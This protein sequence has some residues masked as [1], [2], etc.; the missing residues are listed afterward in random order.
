MLV[1]NLCLLAMGLSTA[2]GATIPASPAAT[3]KTS[4][5]EATEAPLETETPTTQVAAPVPKDT[6]SASVCSQKQL[7]VTSQSNLDSIASCKT[8]KGDIVFSHSLESA[9]LEGVEVIEGSLKAFNLTNLNWVAAPE[10]KEITGTLQLT[11]LERLYRASFPKL[12]KVGDINL[13]TLN[14][15]RKIDLAAGIQEANGLVVSDTALGSLE[16]VNAFEELSMLRIDNNKDITQINFPKLK[17]AYFITVSSN[18]HGDVGVSVK[19]PEL[20]QAQEF[21]LQDISDIDAAKLSHINNTFSIIDTKAKVINFPQLARVDDSFSILSNSNLN[22]VTFPK[23]ELVGGGF[24]ISKNRNLETISS[25]SFP[26]LKIVDGSVNIEGPIKDAT[27]PSLNIV[28]GGLE[29]ESS[30]T[31]FECTFFDELNQEQ[32]IRG[33]PYVCK[34]GDTSSNDNAFISASS[35]TSSE[36]SSST[37]APTSTLAASMSATGG[38][39]VETSAS[40]TKAPENSGN[41]IQVASIW[42]VIAS[43]LFIQLL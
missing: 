10:L 31:E 12:T 39:A 42:T 4:V 7:I 32:V 14:R 38:K 2:Y 40:E 29:V 13:I 6:K 19:F 8:F 9:S 20:T 1:Q 41:T 22:N 24:S 17:S 35:D 21:T 3:I 33:E 18:H 5:V 37:A 16:G 28:R 43:L 15:L 34:G 11:I 30:S 26:E 27:F 23:L 25:K 36:T